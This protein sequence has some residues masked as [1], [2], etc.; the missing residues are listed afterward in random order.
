MQNRFKKSFFFLLPMF[1]CVSGYFPVFCQ[2]APG[3]FIITTRY[4]APNDG[5]ASREVFCAI[6]DNDGFMWFGTRNG[7]N[8]YD[9][10]NFKLFTKQKDGLAE[11][12]IIQLAKDDHDHL[13]IVY[14][15]PGYARSAMRVEVMDLRT[16]TLKSLKETFPGMPFNE[17]YVYWIAN[18]GDDLCFLVSNPFRYWR[19]TPKGFEMKCEMKAWYEPGFDSIDYL[20][21]TGRYFTTT[22]PYCQFYQDCALLQ[23]STTFPQY[24]CTATT[25]TA[26]SNS[27]GVLIGR[28]KQV[29]YSWDYINSLL[30]SREQ[31]EKI[32]K[33]N[34]VSYPTKL[35]YFLSGNFS[36]ALVYT[37]SDGLFLYDFSSLDKLLA[38]EA[39]NIST[40]NGL[41]SYFIDRQNN[42][43]ICTAGGLMKIKREKNLFSHYFTKEQLKDS[44]ENQTRGIY[45]DETGNVY[46]AVWAKFFYN[47]GYENKF[48]QVDQY[49]I[50]YGVSRC[51]NKIY[52]GESNIYLFEPGKNDALKRLTSGN[53]Q[54][55]WSLDSLAP[56]KL[57]GGSTESI[58]T[59]DINTNGLK[60]PVYASDLIPKAQ[61]VYRFL[62]RKDKKTWA[63]AQNGLYLLNENADT[64]T[65]YFGKASKDSSHRLPFDLL[66]DAYEDEPGLF[67]LQ[68]MDRVYSG[69]IKIKIPGEQEFKQ[70][71]SAEGLPSDI[72]Y[73]IESDN[74][75][76]LWISTDNGLVRFNTK[77]FKAHTYTTADGISHDEFNR[78]S[79][80]KAKDGRLFFGGIKWPQRLL[81]KEFPGRFF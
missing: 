54:E 34:P 70:F 33:P 10:K 20:S 2:D 59:F 38:P 22:G 62:R 37:E 73:R 60:T 57:L 31:K 51:M 65:D 18:G 42:I 13:F 6:Q 16:N 75:N 43:W 25:S 27:R 71:T 45:A 29:A 66:H 64:I 21:S 72:L 19:L 79:S 12:K 52:V 17:D 28:N 63:V 80:F 58:F 46:S 77:D 68:P 7:L 56:N 55:I 50:F 67:G 61:F 39:L 48:S 5:L 74:Y 23:V 36:N 15:N 4:F 24:F 40:G 3:D 49:R 32:I 35:I 14:G 76:N 30:N 47:S 41:Y 1:V 81:S 26:I 69:G 53:L 8:R 11:N 9:G 78:A 44:S